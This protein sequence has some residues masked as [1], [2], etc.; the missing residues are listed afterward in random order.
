MSAIVAP[1]IEREWLGALGTLDFRDSY[2]I[3]ASALGLVVAMGFFASLLAEVLVAP[4][5]DRGCAR[6]LVFIGMLFNVA[7]LFAMSVGKSVMPWAGS[8][9]RTSPALPPARQFRPSSSGRSGS[10]RRFS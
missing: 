1:S 7:G 4:L 8:W 10:P 3:S 6:R 2:G 9:R 5:A